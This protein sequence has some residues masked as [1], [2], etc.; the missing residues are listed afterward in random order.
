MATRSCISPSV[1][2]LLIRL[3]EDEKGRRWAKSAKELDLEMLC[4]SQFTLYHVMKVT[5]KPYQQPIVYYI[6]W[7][8]DRVTNPIS[9][10]PWEEKKVNSCMTNFWLDWEK[11]TR[12]IK[13]RQ[14]YLGR[15][16]RWVD[17]PE[18]HLMLY[19]HIYQVELINDGPVT[20]ELEAV[21][22]SP[23]PDTKEKPPAV[24]A[25]ESA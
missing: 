20:L 12:K 6:I 22:P 3:W 9:T 18:A 8:S 1:H 5:D 23:K 14:E 17:Q 16:C 19:V 4:V 24:P 2:V 7:L 15:W 11:G 10:W 25:T 21:P 13:S